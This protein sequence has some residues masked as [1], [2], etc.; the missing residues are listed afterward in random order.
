MLKE[1]EPV[2][3]LKIIDLIIKYQKNMLQINI[4]EENINQKFRLKN[5]DEAKKYFIDEIKQNELISN[6]HKKVCKILNYTEQ[7][8]VLTCTVTGC[9]PI[10]ASASLAGISVGKFCI[11][12]KNLCNNCR[13]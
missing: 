1:E 13:N 5:I 11:K 12:N 6:Q 10:S 4:S 8:L 2:E 3:L 7:L 9:V